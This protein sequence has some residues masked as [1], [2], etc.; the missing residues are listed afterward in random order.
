MKDKEIKINDE[1][2]NLLSTPFGS[3]CSI[4]KIIEKCKKFNKKLITVGDAVTISCL[5]ANYKPFLSVFDFKTLRAEISEKDK[6]LIKKSFK[7]I[8]KAKNSPGCL[9][10]ALLPIAKKLMSSNSYGNAIL[11]EGEEDITGLAFMLYCTDKHVITYGIKD[12]GPVF[13]PGENAI[14]IAK[15]IFNTYFPDVDI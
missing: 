15:H 14:T 10:L 13:V 8:I 6:E 9:N 3:F 2:R 11:I 4:N 1:L 12:K 7:N 5:K